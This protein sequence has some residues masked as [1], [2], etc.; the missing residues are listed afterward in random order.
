MITLTG[1]LSGQRAVAETV[2]R[3]LP[4]WFGI[5]DATLAYIA[6]ADNLPTFVAYADGVPVGFLTLRQHSPDA[7]EISVMGVLPAMH[8]HGVGRALVEAAE[9]HLKS[10]A[11]RFLQVK[12]LSPQHPDKGYAK[13]REF[14]QALGFV[15]LEEFPDLWDAGNPCLQLIKYLGHEML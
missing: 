2:L 4:E 12:T 9:A 6:Q 11:I 13:T 3:A 5:E 1:P 8:R 14:Y 10:L 15:W 7:A